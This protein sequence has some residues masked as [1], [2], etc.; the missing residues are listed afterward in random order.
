M[1]NTVEIDEKQDEPEEQEPSQKG[2]L[3]EALAALKVVYNYISTIEMQNTL[4]FSG[5]DELENAF[6]YEM[7]TRQFFKQDNEKEYNE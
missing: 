7:K 6:T 4:L 5:T 3:R 1:I 2:S